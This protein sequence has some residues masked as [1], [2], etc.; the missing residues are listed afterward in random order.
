LRKKIQLEAGEKLIVMGP[1]SES[2]VIL[3]KADFL[4]QILSEMEKGQNEL[5][6]YLIDNPLSIENQD[7][8]IDTK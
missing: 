5:K 6:K 7:K 3:L 2:I 4:T 8:E 1:E